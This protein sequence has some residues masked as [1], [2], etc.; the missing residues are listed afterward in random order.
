[1]LTSRSFGTCV[2]TRASVLGQ[3]LDQKK[4]EI[5][6][7]E[8][9]HQGVEKKEEYDKMGLVNQLIEMPIEQT[10]VDSFR[11]WGE[12]N[13][14]HWDLM[15][16]NGQTIDTADYRVIGDMAQKVVDYKEKYQVLEVEFEEP[17][18]K[19]KMIFP[20]TFS[21]ACMAGTG[22]GGAWIAHEVFGCQDP[23]ICSL[24]FSIPL[25]LMGGCIDK[26]HEK[27]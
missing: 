22:I 8:E 12:I 5:K 24:S 26:F 25:I 4:G 20:S 9:Q 6:R 23:L 7:L 11:T 16:K 15:K 17:E 21:F 3:V 18:K 2:K 27:Q 14:Q 1:M 13:F 19:Q 10:H